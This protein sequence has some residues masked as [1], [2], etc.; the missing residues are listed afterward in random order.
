MQIQTEKYKEEEPKLKTEAEIFTPKPE[1]FEKIK[2]EIFSIENEN[3]GDHSF[4][5][6]SL[7]ED[8]TNPENIIVILRDPAE[9]DKIIGFT[10]AEPVDHFDKNRKAE[11]AVTAYITDTAL[12]KE[13]QGRHLVGIMMEKLED[14]MKKRGFKFVE[15]DSRVANK[16]ADNVRKAYKDRIVDE[17]GPSKSEWGDQIFFRIRL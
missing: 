12:L 2:F 11:S 17:K 5:E 16:Y 8:F 14:E 3:F 15:R 4:D 9:N 1:S 7:T 10:Y 13:Y 6:E